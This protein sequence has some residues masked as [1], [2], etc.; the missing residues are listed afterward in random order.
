MKLVKTNLPTPIF[1]AKKNTEHRTLK[2]NGL[3]NAPNK[4]NRNLIDMIKYLERV[5]AI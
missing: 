3:M 1:A 5:P 2:K 4:K